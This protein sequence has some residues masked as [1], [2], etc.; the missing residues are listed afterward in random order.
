MSRFEPA[1]ASSFPAVTIPKGNGLASVSS[2]GA[3]KGPP[4]LH[5][6]RSYGF[7]G[8]HSPSETGEAYFILSNDRDEVW[9]IANRH[10]RTWELRPET[11]ALRLA[12][13]LSAAASIDSSHL[14]H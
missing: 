13:S 9:F 7:M 14:S 5:R 4:R 11:N 3:I 12:L 1:R 2:Y 8:V 6:L 10:F